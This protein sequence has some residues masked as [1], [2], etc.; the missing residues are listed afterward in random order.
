MQEKKIKEKKSKKAVIKQAKIKPQSKKNAVQ[1]IR[2]HIKNSNSVMIK[3]MLF[4]IIFSVLNLGMSAYFSKNMRDLSERSSSVETARNY[5]NTWVTDLIISITEGSEFTNV[6]SLDNCDYAKWRAAFDITDVKKNKEAKAAFDKA[7]EIHDEIH[8]IYKNNL[9]VTIQENPEQGLALVNSITAKYEEFSDNIDIVTAFYAKQTDASYMATVIQVII[10]IVLSLGLMLITTRIIKIHANR[11]ANKI[12]EPVNKVADWAGE[13][14]LGSD[15][16]DFGDATTTIEEINTMIDAFKVMAGG[17]QENVHVVER[18]AE[19]DMTAFVNIRSTQDRLS[20]NLYKMVQNNDLM[21]NEITQIA[22]EVAGGAD[23]IANASSS[24]AANC[25]QQIHNIS[26]FK[27][28]LVETVELINKNVER[29]EK[30]KELTGDI[31]DE[32]ALNNEKMEQLIKAMEDITESSQKIFAVITTI[33]EIADQT[34]LLALNASIEAARA[35]EAGKGFAVVANEVG[36]LAAQSAN[37]VIASRKLI[38][39]TITKANIGNEITNETSE[40]FNKI[41]ERVDTIYQFNDEMSIAGQE[42]KDKMAKIE[43]GIE[44]IADAVDTNAAISE[45]TSAS[46]DLLNENAERLRKAMERFNLRKREPGK[47][48]I[49]PEKQDDEAFIRQAQANYEKAVEEGRVTI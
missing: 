41:V 44:E 14:A 26:D 1:A 31:K 5:V 45:E 11:L 36:S 49:P 17:I 27:D 19:G 15:Q 34:N 48:Y 39:D 4:L 12:A 40:T 22:G 33:E 42:Q 24:L 47:A 9:D 37:A 29:I 16:I 21:F 7:L 20:Q 8:L 18:V 3:I 6:T 46:C 23:D 35:G 10:S 2:Q 32:V 43:T 38:E 30:S 28:A 25:T 13:L